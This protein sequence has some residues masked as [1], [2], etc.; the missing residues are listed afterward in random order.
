MDSLSDSLL[1][2]VADTSFYGTTSHPPVAGKFL[3]F[4]L[5]VSSCSLEKPLKPLVKLNLP[6]AVIACY[7]R[8]GITDLFAW[9][10]ECLEKASASGE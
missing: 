5:R 7:Q 3:S 2:A 8:S 6:P 10:A 9:Q 1:A 4:N